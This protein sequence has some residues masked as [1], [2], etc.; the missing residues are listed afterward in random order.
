MELA[1]RTANAS[2]LERAGVEANAFNLYA[3]H[4]FGE[5]GGV[6][7]GKADGDTPMSRILTQAQLDANAYLK[8]KTK[9]ET[10]ANWAERARKA[11]VEVETAPLA[12]TLDESAAEVPRLTNTEAADI[13]DTRLTHLDEL[14][15]QN[16]MTDDMLANLRQ[17]DAD[18]VAQLRTQERRQRD[19]ILP[20]DPRARLSDQ[21]VQTMSARRVEI[22]QAI[23]SHRAAVG[24]ENQA[25]QLRQR[26][27]R[28]DRDADLVRLAEKLREPAAA[29][30][31]TRR[32]AAEPSSQA[33]KAVTKDGTKTAARVSRPAIDGEGPKSK[34]AP[35][36]PTPMD[37]LLRTATELPAA[38][39]IAGF[40]ADGLPTYRPLADAV[41]EIQAEQ[42]RAANDAQA[43]HAAVSCFIRMGS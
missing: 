26:L 30:Q 35:A 22:R 43:Y 32:P 42:T 3:T 24:Y 39:T 31:S 36:A 33:P 29:R 17:E 21:Q 19:N 28:I 27:D 41:A 18:I 23:E 4:H 25:V 37:D 5:G 8:G 15:G 2:A 38:Q 13:I 1:L 20:A 11:G 34:Q 16:R 40:D 14:S 7:F 9:A 10:I 12:Q 6:K